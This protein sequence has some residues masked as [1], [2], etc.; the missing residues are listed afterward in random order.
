MKSFRGIG[1]YDREA[2]GCM[3]GSGVMSI[4]ALYCCFVSNGGHSES[5]RLERLL[6]VVDIWSSH[7]K[8][9]A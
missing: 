8:S 1:I 3:H 2:K 5:W 4:I 6:V 7:F 9:S